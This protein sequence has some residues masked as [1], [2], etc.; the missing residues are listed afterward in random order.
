MLEQNTENIPEVDNPI[1]GDL[2]SP[3]WGEAAPRGGKAVLNRIIKEKATVPLFFGQTLISSLRDVGYNST[4]SA[5]CEHVDNA[6]QW[7]ATEVRVYFRQTGKKGAY[8]TD[9]VV[10]DN[11]IGMAPNILRFATS[12]GGSMVY[13]NR[14]GIGRYGMGMKTAALSMCPVMD[15]YSWQ[16][17]GAYYNMTLDVEAIGK[18]RANLIELPDPALMDELP[19]EV[20]EILTKPMSFP[21]RSEQTLFAEKVGDLRDRLGRS[22]TIV[23]LPFCDRLTF[24]KARTLCEHAIK[25]MARVYRR[26]LAK[27]IKLYVNNRLVEP[28]D[29][30][31]SMAAAR[32]A[33]IPEIKVK[34]SR[35]VFSK[36]IEVKR[37][38]NNRQ[39]PENAE[40]APVTVRLYALPIEDWGALPFKVRKNDLHLYD[41]N[42]VSVLRNDREVFV[43]TIPQIMKRHSDAN[44]LRIQIDFAGEL[45]EAF[46]VASNKQGIRPKDYVLNE[47]SMALDAEI[48]ALRDQIKKYQSEQTVGRHGNKPTEGEMKA[49][50]AE[51]RQAKPVPAPAPTT[52]EEQRQLDENLRTLAMMLKREKE[53]DEEAFERVKNSRYIMHYKHDAYW[54]FYHVDQRYGKIILTINTAHAFYERLYAPLS[55]A[56][57]TLD[58][59]VAEGAPANGDENAAEPQTFKGAKEA[60]V[61][62]Q[63]LLLSLART[64][65]VMA[66]QDPERVQT[67][68]L[69]R[70]EWSDTYATQLGTATV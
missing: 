47:L 26:F 11:G 19:S 57:L 4:T 56:A 37:K 17:A 30:T 38:E 70:K 18:E 29:P 6:L 51:R 41:D 62:L 53:T 66:L 42:T 48:S 12:F 32:H 50:E 67:F 2:Q 35:L 21:D 16:E 43:G 68:D 22:G 14:S 65:S 61:A 13:D 59:R 44:W 20:S 3:A 52:E 69:F 27:G 55:S 54:P 49:D 39:D 28:F 15:L 45:D 8:E 31:Y 33:N 36:V 58:T 60:L 9:I 63:L 25:E 46:G 24:A 23:F 64:Q 10:L 34:E 40:T 1:P 7:G 5:L